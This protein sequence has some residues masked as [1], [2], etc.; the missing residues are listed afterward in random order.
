MILC[1]FL[2]LMF[3][4]MHTLTTLVIN[5]SE[6]CIPSHL[7]FWI[8]LKRLWNPALENERAK[9]THCITTCYQSNL[10]PWVYIV[11]NILVQ[12]LN[13]SSS[14]HINTN[15]TFGMYNNIYWGETTNYQVLFTFL[16]RWNVLKGRIIDLYMIK[17]NRISN[18]NNENTIRYDEWIVSLYSSCWQCVRPVL[19]KKCV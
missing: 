5:L 13:A 17:Y 1:I 9:R 18:R 8:R 16:F 3:I 12:T 19:S 10:R 15:I 14:S 7:I 6:I 2:Q 4:Y 11:S